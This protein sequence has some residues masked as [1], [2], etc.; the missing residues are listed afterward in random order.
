MDQYYNYLQYCQQQA[1]KA[2]PKIYH[3]LYPYVIQIGNRE[4]TEDNQE[5]NPFPGERK[6]DN[7]VDEI[8]DMYERDNNPDEYD[9]DGDFRQPRRRPF[10]RDLIRILLLRDLVGR[11]R[12]RRPFY[13]YPYQTY[14][15]YYPYQGYY[16]YYPY[17]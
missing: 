14:Y 16:D 15:D 4:D 8:Y 7:M 9:E 12:R 11:R 5:M 2:Y 13:G 1:E 6:I 3:R 17:Y 10:T